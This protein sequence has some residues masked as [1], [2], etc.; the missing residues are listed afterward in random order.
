V[1]KGEY[2]RNYCGGLR[3]FMGI[4]VWFSFT[5]E[6]G[7]R[8]EKGGRVGGGIQFTLTSEH[9]SPNDIQ[10]SRKGWAFEGEKSR[11]NRGKE[12]VN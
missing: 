10:L 3:R 12:G 4:C 1:Q 7:G 8:R 5:V 11:K 6:K 2:R 9:S